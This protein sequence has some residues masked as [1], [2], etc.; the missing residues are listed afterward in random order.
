MLF[1]N[2]I[3][4]KNLYT[5]AQDQENVTLRSFLAEKGPFLKEPKHA[6]CYQLFTFFKKIAKK[7]WAGFPNLGNAQKKGCFFSGKASLTK[8][9]NLKGVYLLS[10][11]CDSKKE[12]TREARLPIS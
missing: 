8:T 4:I 9:K 10:H 12:V 2:P 6:T 1:I 5:I 7:I 3:H 11:F